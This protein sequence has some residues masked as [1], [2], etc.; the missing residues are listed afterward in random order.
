MKGPVVLLG[1]PGAGKSTV[2]PRAASAAGMSFVDLDDAIAADAGRPVDVLFKDEGEASFRVREVDALRLALDGRNVLVA[3]GAGVVDTAPGRA[4]LAQ[5]PAV[6]LD[7]PGALAVPRLGATTRPWLPESPEQQLDVRERREAPRRGVRAALAWAVVDGVG[8]VDVVGERLTAALTGLA[9]IPALA[10]PGDT[11]ELAGTS[12]IFTATDPVAAA[13]AS[14]PHIVVV[15]ERAVVDAHGVK[16]DI[17]LDGGE[18]LKNMPVVVRLAA[19]IL[20]AGVQRS[21]LV[22][23][24]G[25]GALLDTVGLAA[26]LLHRG[27]RWAAVPTTLLAQVDAGLGGKT[28]VNLAG[29]KNLLG[30]FHAPVRTVISPGFLR[31]LDAA[32]LRAGATEM[33]KHE[34]LAADAPADGSALLCAPADVVRRSLAIKASVVVR[35]VEERGLRAVLNLG[36]TLAHGLEATTPMSHG[37]AVRHGLLFALGLSV[38]V[39][40]LDA[41]VALT[42]A[43]RVQALGPLVDLANLGLDTDRLRAAMAVDKKSGRWVLLRAPGLPV[44]T[45]VEPGVIDEALARFLG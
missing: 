36:H 39:A 2:G 22:V 5:F 14:H 31:T 34:F 26:A 44:V 7:V 43:T 16:A 29:K 41:A 4:L 45:P 21:S 17:V 24:V 8:R 1:P 30:A 33:L 10:W 32:T 38:Q 42:L 35:D 11:L 9:P 28:A 25:G 23:G 40:G 19:E 27:V 3:A 18:A 13:R 37:E 12:V 20:Q 15:A 6:L